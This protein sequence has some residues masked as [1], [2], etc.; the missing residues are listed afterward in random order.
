MPYELEFQANIQQA[1]TYERKAE[2]EAIVELLE[3]MLEDDKNE[4]L[5]QVYYALAEVTRRENE[6][7]GY[8]LPREICVH[9]R[10]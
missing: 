5:D 4:I 3:D 7:R 1:M 8:V 9:E 10:W 2:G 6:R